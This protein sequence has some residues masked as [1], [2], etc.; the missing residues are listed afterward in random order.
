MGNSRNRMR[1]VLRELNFKPAIYPFRVDCRIV[2]R[3]DLHSEA[4]LRRRSSQR[5]AHICHGPKAVSFYRMPKEREQDSTPMTARHG[6]WHAIFLLEACEMKICRSPVACR[7]S[8]SRSRYVITHPAARAHLE[9][10]RGTDGCRRQADERL[11]AR[12]GLMRAIGPRRLST[13]SV[14]SGFGQRPRPRQHRAEASCHRRQQRAP[15]QSTLRAYRRA[16]ALI[17]NTPGGSQSRAFSVFRH[18]D[19][20]WCGAAGGYEYGYGYEYVFGRRLSAGH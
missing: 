20:P 8:T 18:A 12:E 9:R 4:P 17:V 1:Q 7:A 10:S 11:A 2:E 13:P 5:L 14:R 6:F 19:S 3:E 16:L 15:V